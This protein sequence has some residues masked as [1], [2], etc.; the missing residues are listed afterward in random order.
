M[1]TRITKGSGNVFADIG[2]RHPEEHLVKAELV[3]RIAAIIKSER[4]TQT[5]V[6]ERLGIAQPD[7]SRMLN[8]HFRQFSVERLMRFLVALGQS[9]EIIV[10]PAGAD[11]EA[12]G[13]RVSAEV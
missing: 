2:L 10:R 13:I 9:V 11:S 5:A 1:T 4:M 7:V 8:G 3:H 12:A 6:A